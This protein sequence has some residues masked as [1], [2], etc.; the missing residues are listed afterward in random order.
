MCKYFWRGGLCLI[1]ALLASSVHLPTASA[2]TAA[3]AATKT[4]GS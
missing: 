4:A 1:A 3:T 2:D